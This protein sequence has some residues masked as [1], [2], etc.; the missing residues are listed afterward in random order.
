MKQMTVIGRISA[1]LLCGFFLLMISSCTAKETLNENMGGDTNAGK[2]TGEISGETADLDDSGSHALQTGD[3]AY[4]DGADSAGLT[5]S[6]SLTEEEEALMSGDSASSLKTSLTQ[7]TEPRDGW[8][9][10]LDTLNVRR[11]CYSHGTIIG[12]FSC[13][14]KI[15][16]NGPARYGFYPVTGIDAETG[17]EITGYCSASYISLIEYTGNAVSLDIVSFT[18]TDE[19][20]SELTLGESR[21]TIGQVGCTT[22]CFAM[23]ESY[24]TGTEITPADMSQRLTYTYDGNLFWPEDYYQDYTTDYLSE[25]YLK[26]HQGIPVLIGSRRANGSQHWVLVT[27]YDPGDTTVTRSAQLKASDFII[28]DP[29]G[30]RTNLKQFFSDLPYYIKIAYYT[31]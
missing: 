1:L 23:S 24:L 25:I 6:D 30:L 27:G 8:V 13:G 3:L 2:E 14:Q 7:V 21:F 31:G 22:T 18:Q 15:A 28:Q 10:A 20:W 19:R 11:F 4:A 9:I 29:S 17:E 12:T 16:V 26:L 5:A